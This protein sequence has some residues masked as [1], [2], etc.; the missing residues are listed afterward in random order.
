[1]EANNILHSLWKNGGLLT[2][3]MFCLLAGQ[4]SSLPPSVSPTTPIAVFPV[5]HL[6]LCFSSLLLETECLASK[7]AL[8]RIHQP[9]QYPL[10]NASSALLAII[11]IQP[12][13]AFGTDQ[14][15]CFPNMLQTPNSVGV[16]HQTLDHSCTPKAIY[17]VV[18]R[19]VGQFVFWMFT[20]SWQ[21]SATGEYSCNKK[22]LHQKIPEQSNWNCHG[23]LV[24]FWARSWKQQSDTLSYRTGQKERF[25]HPQN[26][27]IWPGCSTRISK[28]G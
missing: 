28:Q 25:I 14:R 26:N 15:T 13:M 11:F 22:K 7:R 19:Q 12:W 16:G 1:M 27:N 5:W 6:P 4:L 8:G 9:G 3:F 2:G 17:H 24:V 23:H 20:V 18:S 21:L 10:E